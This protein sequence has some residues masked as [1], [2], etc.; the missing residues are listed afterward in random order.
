[1]RTHTSKKVLLLL[2]FQNSWA[3]MSSLASSST[4]VLL[5]EK[6]SSQRLEGWLNGHIR[7]NLGEELSG[8]ICNAV[9]PDRWESSFGA[10]QGMVDRRG[11]TTQPVGKESGGCQPYQMCKP[12]YVG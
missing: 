9:I 11:N 6:L 12:V 7:A 10:A 2:L 5:K 4:F 8:D 1:M 3:L